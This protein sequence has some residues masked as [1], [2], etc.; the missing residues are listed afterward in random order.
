MQTDPEPLG[1][2]EIRA[3]AGALVRMDVWTLRFH[4]PLR[5]KRP[6]GAKQKGHRFFDEAWAADSEG[7]HRAWSCL[8]DA[9][10]APLPGSAARGKTPPPEV[11]SAA[12]VWVDVPYGG[13]GGKTLGGVCGEVVFRGRLEPEDAE[14]AVM[15]QYLGTGKNA[16]FGFGFYE[17]PELEEVRRVR[18]PGRGK[19]LLARGLPPD[20]LYR[21]LSS[22]APTDPGRLARLLP[23]L[24]PAEPLVAAALKEQG[25]GE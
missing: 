10:R 1:P 4:S 2:A 8:M 12:L 7:K 5:L 14:R 22:P 15:G 18:L 24:F 25:T 6:A 21:G 19:S 17:I 3:E 23:A 16:A 20:R 11:E 9:V 13:T